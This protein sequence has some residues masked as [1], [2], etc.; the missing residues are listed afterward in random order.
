MFLS[1]T[2]K[3][4][5]H[6]IDNNFLHVL[7]YYMY[8]FSNWQKS[9]ATWN[10]FVTYIA[11]IVYIVNLLKQRV[12]YIYI[13]LWQCQQNLKWPNPHTFL[14]S[15]LCVVTFTR[16]VTLG[17]DTFPRAGGVVITL[18]YTCSGDQPVYVVTFTRV[19]LPSVLSQ[20]PTHV[21]AISLYMW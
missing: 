3:V 10:I 13:H 7:L 4:T 2:I 20:L 17:V 14:R 18:T 16:V 12:V 8:V 21:R 1:L 5:W 9:S 15:A 6:I 11:H 19:Q